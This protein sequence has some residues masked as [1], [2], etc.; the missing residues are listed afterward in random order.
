VKKWDGGVKPTD[1][2][3]KRV[4]NGDTDYSTIKFGL[5][6]MS[7]SREVAGLE[8]GAAPLTCIVQ[9]EEIAKI[10]LVANDDESR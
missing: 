1:D 6:G 9:V 4:S 7:S 10:E 3:E 5:E 2:Q 8:T